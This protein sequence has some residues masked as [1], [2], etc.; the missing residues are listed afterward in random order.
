MKS[1]SGIDVA[2]RAW[3]LAGA[4]LPL[5]FSCSP[6]K[7]PPLARDYPLTKIT[8]HVYVIEG[9]NQAP[10][11]ENQG[12]SNNPGFV[13]VRGGVVVIDPGASVQVGELVLGKIATVTRD[14]VIAVFDTNLDG[15]HWLGNQ[16]I[17][18]AYPKA[19]IYAHPKMMEAIKAGAGEAWIKMMDQATQGA[20]RGTTVAAPDL[21]L[22]DGD[23]LRL[24]GTTFRIMHNDRAHG[25]NDIMIE[26]PQEGVIFLGD[27]VLNGRIDVAAPGH[28]SLA[29]QIA[30]IDAALA[31]GATR[32]IPGHGAS[33]GREL[34]LAQRDFLVALHRAV[35]KYY[36]QGL[37]ESEIGGRLGNELSAYR[38][39]VGFDR[40][41]QLA[42]TAYQHGGGSFAR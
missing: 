39:W 21:G 34:A 12:F 31:S 1:G 28:G 13:L 6:A 4:C 5:L 8:D 27:I 35:K 17:K 24:R 36:D 14:P 18:A 29:G 42:D 16:A 40:L 25:D 33:G 41:A 32:F 9:P 15:D 26:V 20:S 37:S 38:D 3:L 19:I 22:E 30:A 2:A 11:R 7:A 10:G 23:A